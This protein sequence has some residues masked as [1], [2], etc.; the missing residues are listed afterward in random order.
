MVSN[1]GVW[2]VAIEEL[3]FARTLGFAI[4][5]IKI[6]AAIPLEHAESHA[7]IEWRDDGSLCELDLDAAGL[8]DLCGRRHLDAEHLASLDVEHLASPGN[9]P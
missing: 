6:L 1:S 2:S 9:S 5:R 8:P 7:L 4:H 3:L